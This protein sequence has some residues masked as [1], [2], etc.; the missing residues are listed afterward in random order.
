MARSRQLG[1]WVLV[2]AVVVVLP[3]CGV[4]ANGGGASPPSKPEAKA[5]EPALTPDQQA[6][7]DLLQRYK[8]ERDIADQEK[9]LL[10]S[11]HM[12]AG[13]EK[14]TIGGDFRGALRDFDKAIE[15]DS[16]NKEAQEYA[17]KARGLL[18]LR[19]GAPGDVLG[20]YVAQEVVARQAIRFE[21]ANL[22]ADAKA[23]YDKGQYA[24][25]IE[26]FTRVIAKARYY[27]PYLDSAKAAE[28]SEVYLRRATNALDEQRQRGQDQRV[29]KAKEESDRLRQQ[30]DKTLNQRSDALYQRA[31]GLMAQG[32]YD[33]ARKVA[34]EILRTD[35]ANGAARGLYDKAALAGRNQAIDEAAR[36]RRLETQFHWNQVTSWLT[37]QGSLV[38]MPREL[39]EL[40]RNRKVPVFLGDERKPPG[41]WETRIREVLNKQVSFDFV[42]TPLPDVVSFLGGL[43]DTTIVLD[44]DVFKDRP[45]SISL[46][47]NDMRLEAALSWIC[48]LAGVSF[49]L[50]NEAIFVS[51]ANKLREEPRLRMYDV[52][53]L[54]LEIPNF[55]GNQ[56]ALATDSGYGPEGA[57]DFGEQFFLKDE[58][59]DKEERLTGR[60][61]VEFIRRIIS[62]GNWIEDDEEGFRGDRS[63]RA[64]DRDKLSGQGL[65][66][67]ISITIGGRTWVGVRNKE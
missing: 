30:R 24:A 53:D 33:E 65:V 12:E 38:F 55:K 67:V 8:M 60:T 34:D 2:V 28:D 50:R 29:R 45:P 48:R 58:D 63:S 20:A 59:K 42:E 18:G 62:P 6:A 32:R 36:N 14:M 35:P 44:T 4:L 61:L 39:M 9:R 37:P 21:V 3:A 22:F 15:L 23:L 17:K 25:A 54:T 1:V 64:D 19:E 56:R 16:Q 11:K 49:G 57:R 43:T 46:R 66:D 51:T 10:A 47:V 31:E 5:A 52:T 40:V 27:A 26:A 7:Q 41:E 13:K